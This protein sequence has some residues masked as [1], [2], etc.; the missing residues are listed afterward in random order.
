MSSALV[1]TRSAAKARVHTGATPNLI[2]LH[3]WNGRDGAHD[4]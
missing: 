1:A 3:K 2:G 4:G